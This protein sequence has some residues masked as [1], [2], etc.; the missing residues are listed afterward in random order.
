MKDLPSLEG[1]EVRASTIHGSGVF[2]KASF[3]SGETILSIDDAR[4]VT[5]NAS[6]ISEEGEYEYH[7]DY[8]ADG[9][10]V[11]MRSPERHINH[12]CCPNTF[13]R[14]YDGRR[15]VIALNDIAS[16]D[17]ISFDYCI[18]GGGDTIWECSCLHE[19]C[20]RQIHS[21]YFNLPIVLQFEYRPLLD[22]WFVDENCIKL[23]QLERSFSDSMA[24]SK[25]HDLPG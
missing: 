18:N 20:R 7:C 1:I 3:R 23:E 17:E 19:R 11:L 10:V 5:L 24:T 9:K 21:S 12:C 15:Y 22:S 14:T 6:L 8:L 25:L 16:G 13:V 4:V 2:T